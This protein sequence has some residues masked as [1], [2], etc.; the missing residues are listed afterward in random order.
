VYIVHASTFVVM[1]GRWL[2]VAVV[3]SVV[4]GHAGNRREAR[5]GVM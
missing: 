3:E 4:G 1:V 5:E 2:F